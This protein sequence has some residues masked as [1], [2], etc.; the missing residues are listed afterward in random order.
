MMPQMCR[1]QLEITT[2]S[3]NPER[4]GFHEEGQA[5]PVS[6]VSTEMPQAFGFSDLSFK[7]AILNQG[8]E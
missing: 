5:T 2:C 7:M 8:P 1:I 4:L 3:K 6:T